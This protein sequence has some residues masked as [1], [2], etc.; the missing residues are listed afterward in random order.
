MKIP[1]EIF[2]NS[3]QMNSKQKNNEM[4]DEFRVSGNENFNNYEYFDALIDYNHSLC[5][6][7]PG[8][9]QVGLA[10]ANRSAVYLELKLFEI[11][12][13][14]IQLAKVSNYPSGRMKELLKREENCKELMMTSKPNPFDDPLKY[15]KLSHPANLK[16]PGI[17]DCI[18]LRI[19]EKFGRHLVTTMELKT[20]DVIAIEDPSS[21]QA[22][23]GARLHRC[24]NCCKDVML[25]MMPCPGCSNGER[26]FEVTRRRPEFLSFPAM[27]CSGKCLLA[28]FIEVHHFECNDDPEVIPNMRLMLKYLSIFDG[29]VV[30]LKKFLAENTK[31][32]T[33]FDF[34]FS[35]PNDPKRG[36]NLMLVELSMRNMSTVAESL[37]YEVADENKS[38]IHRHSKLKELL[39]QSETFHDELLRKLFV[40]SMISE[41][42]SVFASKHINLMDEDLDE[43]GNL[44]LGNICSEFVG[45]GTFP[46]FSLLPASCDCNITC[47]DVSN[48]LVWVANK[49]IPAGAQLFRKNS[50]QFYTAGRAARRSERIE[51]HLAADCDCEACEHDWPTL[52]G[53]H[54]VDPN[55]T[56][57]PLRSLSKPPQAKE[58]VEK[59]FEYIQKN[60]QHNKPTQE[61]YISIY[62]LALELQALAKPS[63]YP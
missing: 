4:A 7:E 1:S 59:Y 62:N 29:S 52:D 24:F 56:D 11:C 15:F 21:T 28:S 44:S 31:P 13:Q 54:A 58:N 55:F 45:I 53:L 3:P 36:K 42:L 10:Y 47:V 22:L 57:Q 18:E 38:L 26:R 33:V 51:L 27:F 41:G 30:E 17:I 19:N 12:L 34:D 16:Y 40:L 6:A 5:F 37:S 23:N 61:V 60:Y 8:S 25:S 32:V 39:G 49:P 48:K 2:F 63:F 35:D 14:N 50:S 20:G 9:E 43:T 46:A